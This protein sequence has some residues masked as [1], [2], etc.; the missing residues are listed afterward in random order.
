MSFAREALLKIP[1][2]S[3]II[4]SGPSQSGKSTLVYDILK[5]AEGMFEKPPCQ[6]IFCYNIYQNGLYD[7]LKK[8][9]RNLR[10]FQGIPTK[11][12]L[13]AWSRGEEHSVLILDDLM[14]KCSASQD[15]SDL[16]TIYA[17]HMNFSL[18]FV[19]QNIYSKGQQFRTISLNAHMF[20][21]FNSPR[22]LLQ[23]KIFASQCFPGETK[24]FMDAYKRATASKFG[25]LVVDLSPSLSA[26]QRQYRLRTNILP[27]DTTI[28]YLP[29]DK[30]S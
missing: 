23:I 3:S 14:A 21:L 26:D 1:S 7:R 24:Y 13:E 30:H 22:D 28:V 6:V 8:D 29:C 25:Y 9:V 11:E 18:F 19:V 27:G 20:I 4:L 15:I 16:F 2:P 10:F 17:H 12:D 5:H